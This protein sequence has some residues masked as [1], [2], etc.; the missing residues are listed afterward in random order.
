MKV[1]FFFKFVN[2]QGKK[3]EFDYD[4]DIPVYTVAGHPRNIF[5]SSKDR[6]SLFHIN[7]LNLNSGSRKLQF[8]AHGFSYLLL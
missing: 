7:F 3:F 8:K 5:V 2:I 4:G 1:F 6:L